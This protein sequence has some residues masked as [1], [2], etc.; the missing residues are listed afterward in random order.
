MAQA[1]LSAARKKEAAAL[2][3]FQML[4]QSLE[5][6]VKFANKE[7]AEAKGDLAA[8]SEAKVAA[9]GTLAVTA[10]ELA[11][12]IATAAD[13]KQN[14]A[15]KAD[16]Y[17]AAKKSRSEELKALADA[18]QAISEKTGGADSIQYGLSQ[19]SFLQIAGRSKLYS[20]ADL[21]KF[22]AVQVVRELAKKQHSTALAQLAQRMAVAMRFSTEAGE[23]PFAKVKGLITDMIAKLEAEAGAD[24]THKA[25]C[26]KEMSATKAKRDDKTA[27]VEKLSTKIE[28]MTATSAKLK[29]EVAA[30]QAS[31][32]DLAKAQ[33]EMDEMRKKESD[34]F[35]K[36]KADMEEGIQ[37]V[38]LALKIL[39]E[40]YAKEDK[41]H[42]A[43][44]AAVSGIV[45]LL[46]V[47]ESDF[48]KTI[49]ELTTTEQAAKNAY[50]QQAKD[51]EIEKTAKDQDV[52]Y[53]VNAATDL[54]KAVAEATS[55]R[56]GVQV[57][58]DAV[59]EYAAKLKE[60]CVF[61]A[62]TYGDRAARREA[63]IAGL[64]EALAILGGEAVLLQQTSRW[65][66]R[67]ARASARAVP[68]M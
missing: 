30:L 24:A 8:S 59:L 21:A 64:K 26:D 49:A 12:D 1:Q 51:N 62:E 52:K 19:V 63:E 27:M 18:K 14:C 47:V 60:M 17:E 68:A 43:A 65:A 11:A 10:K 6:E 67:G 61:K 15:Q 2:H 9:E 35:V 23:D 57:E 29:E 40:Y 25:Y 13:L 7:M 50:D 48:S 5:D 37:G 46:E 45:G 4:K 20:G 39:R 31:L 3:N 53:K 55:D 28:Q 44:G 41:A 38:Q 42:D 22:E 56:S 34:V 16:D 54:D 58:L 32:A 33:G 66:F 36:S